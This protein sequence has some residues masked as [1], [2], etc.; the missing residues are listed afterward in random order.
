MSTTLPPVL[1]PGVVSHRLGT[2]PEPEWL[3][4]L[5][6]SGRVAQHSAAEGV[7]LWNPAGNEVFVAGPSDWVNYTVATQ[8]LT[9]TPGAPQ[10]S[11]VRSVIEHNR[12]QKPYAALHK[13][14]AG[15]TAPDVGFPVGSAEYK[16]NN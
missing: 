3:R 11:G 15:G 14:P 9:W 12:P 7:R 2:Y 6:V 16:R 5:R 4:A 8:R 13:P 1:G 10:Y